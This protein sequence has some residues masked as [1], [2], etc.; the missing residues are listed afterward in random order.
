MYVCVCGGG[1]HSLPKGQQQENY[2]VKRTQ[3]Y[4]QT[5]KDLN[6][7][8]VQYFQKLIYNHLTLSAA[9]L[10]AKTKMSNDKPRGTSHLQGFELLYE[11][12]VPEV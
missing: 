8:N 4:P 3:F 1:G 12:G 9:I 11:Y 7:I 10:T 6:S 2:I 5:R